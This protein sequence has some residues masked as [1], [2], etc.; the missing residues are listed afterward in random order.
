[1]ALADILKKVF[2][3]KSDRDMKQVKPML[4]KVLAAY[5]GIDALSDDELRARSA[6]LRAKIFAVEKPFE[7]RIA[8]IKAELEKD[9]PVSEKEALATESDKLVKDE[10]DAIEKCLDEILPEAFA[11]M[12]STARRFAQN[13]TITVTATDFDR[14]LAA[15]GRDF[16]HIEDDKAVW[17]NHWVAGGNE[18]TWDMVHYD[19]QLIGG[20]VLNG[21]LKTNKEQ[22]GSIAEMA[23]GERHPPGVP[24]RARRQ[25]RP[26]G[27]RQRLPVQA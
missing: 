19:V 20:I 5:P 26:R 6:A 1:M 17:Q 23:T 7:D 2:G 21:S 4:D 18:I 25:G 9:I 15:H 27:H 14:D 13:E 22:R 16:V 8:E 12:K 24:E 10:D 11:I 3:S